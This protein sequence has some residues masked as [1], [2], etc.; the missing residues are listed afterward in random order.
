MPGFKAMTTTRRRPWRRRRRRQLLLH[1]E[2]SHQVGHPQQDEAAVEEHGGPAQQALPPQ[3]DHVHQRRED[4]D[5]S[6]A[7]RR[8]GEPAR[9]A[10]TRRQRPWCHLQDVNVLI[11]NS[12]SC[13]S[14]M[15]FTQ[16]DLCGRPSVSAWTRPSLTEWNEC[17]AV[18]DGTR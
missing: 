14:F 10:R 17:V 1:E 12:M 13:S 9:E 15:L 2:L 16:G 4:K 3:R 5:Q 7:A 11:L 18:V 8:S 6:Q